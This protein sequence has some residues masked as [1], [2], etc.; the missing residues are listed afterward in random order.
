MI[1]KLFDLDGDNKLSILDLEWLRERFPPV[2]ILGQSIKKLHDLYI[3]KNVQPKYVKQKQII[4][5]T[6]F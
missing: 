1:F 2:T 5:F 3:L 6:V 4:G